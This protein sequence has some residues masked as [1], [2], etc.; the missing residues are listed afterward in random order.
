[1]RIF[2]VAVEREGT[3]AIAVVDRTPIPRTVSLVS[4]LFGAMQAPDLD[5]IINHGDLDL[6][7]QFPHRWESC[8]Y[9]LPTDS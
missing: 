9:G 6:E 7:E 2:S 3:I 5:L 1:M 4:Q 8:C